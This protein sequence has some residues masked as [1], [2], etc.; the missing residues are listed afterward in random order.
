MPRSLPLSGN[1]AARGTDVETIT[2]F[3]VGGPL[4]ITAA[5]GHDHYP[6]AGSRLAGVLV[7]DAALDNA[8]GRQSQL[9]VFRLLFVGGVD[10][11]SM[12]LD[13]VVMH[14]QL[15]GQVRTEA[16]DG[17]VA[18]GGHG[19]RNRAERQSF[20]RRSQA[21]LALL[22][23]GRLV[24]QLRDQDAGPRDRFPLQIDY[25]AADDLFRGQTHF[26]LHGLRFCDRATSRR[27]RAHRRQRGFGLSARPAATGTG[28]SGGTCRRRRPGAAE[29]PFAGPGDGL[30]AAEV[31][32]LPGD[33]GHLA[34]A[35]AFPSGPSTRPVTIIS[36]V[37]SGRSWAGGAGGFS[38]LAGGSAGG[39]G[40][41]A[42]G[43]VGEPL[44]FGEAK[45][46][47]PATTRPTVSSRTATIL[48]LVPAALGK[49]PS[50]RPLTAAGTDLLASSAVLTAALARAAGTAALPE[51]GTS[52]AVSSAADS[53]RP[54]RASRSR[55][56]TRA[57]SRR[58]FRVPSEQPDAR[59]A[60]SRVRPSR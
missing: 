12:Q 16:A 13:A 2:A 50:I 11:E 42:A 37:S 55:R 46:T 29:S 57:C 3:L 48:N 27:G 22:P 35:T 53:A 60:S 58:R 14:L 32:P 4:H 36:F 43:A 45:V 9:D 49:A 54:R 7:G 5:G 20:R 47:A 59:A 25:A 56:A 28:R 34:P 6:D 24:C 41:F 44:G 17:E 21:A 19:C 1:C 15:H 23:L 31:L 38:A 10:G 52:A 8:A 51:S 40:S 30:K 18:L 33:D 26:R 39:G